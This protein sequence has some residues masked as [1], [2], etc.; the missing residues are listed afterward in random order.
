MGK[1]AAGNPGPYHGASVRWVGGVVPAA[2]K[3]VVWGATALMHAARKGHTAVVE[4]L[5]GLDANVQATDD[6]GT[7]NKNGDRKRHSTPAQLPHERKNR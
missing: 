4:T 3:Y 2:I 6:D 5:V 1:G 7:K